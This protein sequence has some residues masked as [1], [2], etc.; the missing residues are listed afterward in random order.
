MNF[1]KLTY[2]EIRSQIRPIWHKDLN[3]INLNL[4]PN[5]LI[6]KYVGNGFHIYKSNWSD[7]HN[8]LNNSWSDIYKNP[9]LWTEQQESEKINQILNDWFMKT[10]L[11]P[12]MLT[13]NGYGE[14]VPSDGKHRLKV[15]SFLEENEIYFILFDVDIQI[16]SKYFTPILII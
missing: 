6:Q 16:V 5:K 12:P 13:D 4:Q 11:I 10:P 8:A 14:L 1:K 3:D 9:E 7:L 15:S 2:S